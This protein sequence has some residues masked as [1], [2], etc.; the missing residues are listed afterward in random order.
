MN[1]TFIATLF[2][3]LVGAA[4]FAASP[5]PDVRLALDETALLPGTPTGVTVTIANSG[6]HEVRLPSSLWLTAADEAGKTFTLRASEA[7]DGAAAGV[8]PEARIVPARSS[9]EL[10]F[11]PVFFILGSPW[12][13]DER[14]TPGRYRVRAVFAP[15]VHPDGTFD[16]ASAVA[17]NEQ[18]LTIAAASDEDRAVWQWMLQKGGGKWGQ[19]EWAQYYRD[20]GEFVA[21]DHPRSEYAL[22]AAAFQPHAHGEVPAMLAEQVGRFPS[23]SFSDQAK[24]LLV[25]I[26]QQGMST[27][28]LQA[29]MQRAAEESDAARALASELLNNSRSS[30]VRASARELL[31]G[32]P[33]REQ[34]MQKPVTR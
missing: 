21:R 4:A 19:R 11:D 25:Q 9:R 17:S 34:L 15:L 30:R 16:A 28:R 3:L 26:H 2:S 32:I 10:R 5:A 7:S 14:L 33:T 12:F 29:N 13:L 31:E 1:R 20:F 23:R 27:A 24:L 18:E 22:F 6:D 8:A